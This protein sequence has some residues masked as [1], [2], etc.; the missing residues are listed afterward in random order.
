MFYQLWGGKVTKRC[1]QITSF[2]EKGEPKQR[3]E[4]TSTAYPR[5][6]LPI[7]QLAIWRAGLTSEVPL[8]PSCVD[9][10]GLQAVHC[11]SGVSA[12]S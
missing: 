2:E 9:Y 11:I 4:P 6:A 7:G 3:I 1:P 8:C 12:Y 10:E 5:D